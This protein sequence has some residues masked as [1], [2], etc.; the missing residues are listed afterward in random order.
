MQSIPRYVEKFPFIFIV[1]F[2]NN[3]LSKLSRQNLLRFTNGFTLRNGMHF[4]VLGVLKSDVDFESL[5]VF[6][7]VCLA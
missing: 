6:L 3:E 4:N 5:N 1:F 7:Y 2:Q